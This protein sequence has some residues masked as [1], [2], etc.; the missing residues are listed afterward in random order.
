[1]KKVF[2]Y[3]L[4]VI[5]LIIIS[6]PFITGNLEKEVLNEQTRSK[7]PGSF[8]KL[9]DGY[10][11]YEIK[12]SE[13]GKTIVLVHGNAA[14]YFTWDN[15]YNQLVNAGF[16]VLRYDIYGHGFSDRPEYKK[17][18]KDLYDTQIVELLEELKINEHIYIAGTSQGGSICAYFAAKHP[19]KVEKLALLAPLY[20]EFSGTKTVSIMKNK[21]LGNYIMGVTGDKFSTNPSRVLYSN[22]KV[23]E[24]TDKLRKQI[25]YKGK[26]RAVLA[27]MRGDSLVG[28]EQYYEEVKKENIP[29]L[30]TW[31]ENDKSIPRKSMEKLRRAIPNIEYHEIKQASH[32]AHYEFP[33]EINKILIKFFIE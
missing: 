5:V 15:N 2:L 29:V 31:G 11:H 8:I 22:D 28:N 24:I 23:K 25:H 30:L 6:L 19:K 9:S 12:G 14:P 10:T 21:L 20:D 33:E 3:G 16:R 32:L 27:N 7:L 26:K 18:N 1:M 4:L 17:Y 13:D